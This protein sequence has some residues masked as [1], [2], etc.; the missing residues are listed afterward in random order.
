LD[1]RASTRGAPKDWIDDVHIYNNS[2]ASTASGGDI[3]KYSDGDP[4]SGFSVG[5]VYYYNN[6]NFANDTG[7]DI[8]ARGFPPGSEIIESNNFD[9]DNFAAS[10]YAG[11]T[12]ANPLTPT[13]FLLTG[14]G[15]DIA[16]GAGVN[17]GSIVMRDFFE[18]LRS[19]GAGYD[20]G[21]IEYQADTTLPTITEVTLTGETLI[22]TGTN[23]GVYTGDY[24]YNSDADIN[25]D[26]AIDFLD[27][28]QLSIHWGRLAIDSDYNPDADIDKDGII[29]APDF[30]ILSSS[31][32]GAKATTYVLFTNGA[33]PKIEKERDWSDTEIISRLPYSV[34]TG[35]VGVSVV[36]ED[37]TSEVFRFIVTP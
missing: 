26:G 4:G 32:G 15:A 28:V 21:A 31:W 16:I 1:Y 24:K 27:F 2:F 5:T 30:T 20:I 12:P 37:G 3:L 23:F 8:E 11:T 22:I 6:I 36:T 25:K 17:L 7:V 18:N 29:G 10:P 14:P 9:D 19:A 13:D 34:G 35:E 33:I